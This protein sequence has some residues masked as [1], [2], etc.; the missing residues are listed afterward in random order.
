MP[1]A[2]RRIGLDWTAGI[3]MGERIDLRRH[4]VREQL[5]FVE[6]QKACFQRSVTSGGRQQPPIVRC[7]VLL[8]Y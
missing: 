2:Y 5:C 3:G 6:A 1:F 4:S 8:Q 7:G